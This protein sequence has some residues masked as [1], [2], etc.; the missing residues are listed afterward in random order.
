MGYELH[1][2]SCRLTGLL[3]KHRSLGVDRAPISYSIPSPESNESVPWYRRIFRHPVPP[4]SEESNDSDE[5]EIPDLTVLEARNLHKTYLLGLEG[6]PALRGVNLRISRGEFVIIVGKSGSGKS[7]LL[8][9]LGTVDSPTRGEL[10]ISGLLFNDKTQDKTVSQIRLRSIG[11]VFQTFNLIPGMTAAQNVELPLILKGE[12]TRLQRRQAVNELLQRVGMID[13]GSHYP[14]QLS[15]G[16]QQR[17]S[18][19]RGLANTPDM[20]LLDEPTGDLDTLNTIRIMNLLVEL[21]NMGTT[22]IMVTHDMMLPSIATRI[23]VMSDGK[24]KDVIHNDDTTRYEALQKLNEGIEDLTVLLRDGCDVTVLIYIIAAIYSCIVIYMMKKVNMSVPEAYMDEVFHYPMTERELYL[25]GSKDHYFSG[26]IYCWK[27]VFLSIFGVHNADSEMMCPL[28]SLRWMNMIILF[29]TTGT[30]F[31]ILRKANPEHKLVKSFLW[32]IQIMSIPTILCPFFLYYTDGLSLFYSVLSILFAFMSERGYE[33]PYVLTSAVFTALAITVRQ[34]NVILTVLNPMLIVFQRYGI[35]HKSPKYPSFFS[36]FLH[37]VSLLF[38]EF[39]TVFK[40]I[41]PF[42]FILLCFVA[43]FVSNGFS[44]VLGDKEHHSIS[45]HFM[46]ICYFAVFFCCVF[47]DDIVLKLFQ[48]MKN[49]KQLDRS[50]WFHVTLRYVVCCLL[51]TMYDK[52]VDMK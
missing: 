25:L 19:A 27:P 13:R 29:F 37:F 28:S 3:T 11:F 16:E 49:R 7:S 9:I 31:L 26:I 34:T 47:I 17:V 41:L 18:I 32:A 10:E 12:L 4:V 22:L 21:N 24:I 40:I 52:L 6:V 2:H 38:S 14:S 39:H 33:L 23:V 42:L 50:F 20:L 35:L 43:F 45:L 30:V 1:S 51:A 48:R 5:D 46:Q 15:G 8:N 44:V 36:Q